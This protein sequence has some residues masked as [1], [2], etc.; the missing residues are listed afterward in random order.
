MLRT[1]SR[2]LRA[3]L[4]VALACGLPAAWASS[5]PACTLDWHATVSPAADASPANAAPG[6]AASTAPAHAGVSA[7]ASPATAA[8][9]IEVRLSFDAGPRTSTRLSLPAGWDLLEQADDGGPRLQPVAADPRQR[10][11]RHA[12][13]ERIT[14]RWRT[15]AGLANGGEAASGQGARLNPRWF[16]WI[17]DA[18]LPWPDTTAAP[19]AALTAA[20]ASTTTTTQGLARRPF[21]ACI[22][23]DAPGSARL[24]ASHG[25]AE[26]PSAR[27]VLPEASATQVQHALYAGGALA[28]R[29]ADAAGQTLTAV[30]PEPMPGEAA[31]GFGVDALA[32]R[33]ARL[34][35]AL[36]RD[37]QDDDRTPLLLMALPGMVSGGLPLQRA[38]VLQARPDLA[39][40]GAD[41]DALLAGLMLRRWTPERFGPLAHA[42]RGDAP[43]RAWFTEGFADYLAHRLLLREG[44]WTADDY[45]Q[46]LNRKIGR[47][48]AEPERGADNLRLATGAA[49]PRALADLPAARGEWLALHW[50]AALRQAG[51]PGLEATLRKLMLPAAQSRREGPLS[52]PL[53]THRLIAALRRDLGDQPL[54]ELARHIDDGVPFGFSDSSLGPCFRSG[55]RG[56]SASY[57][58]ATTADGLGACQAWQQG[59]A[60]ERRLAAAAPNDTDPAAS[61]ETAALA[62]AGPGSRTG[63]NGKAAKSGKLAKGAKAAKS[64]PGAKAGPAARSGKAGKAG[65][66]AKA[67]ATTRPAAGKPAKASQPAKGQ[68]KPRARS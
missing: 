43:L 38:L 35:G 9:Q 45:A 51:R 26:G 61:A 39:L 1:P 19:A 24:V 8:R 67:G 34:L 5:D 17:G 6:A 58:P 41:S 56:D 25:R 14:L 16:A 7:P 21:S 32:E 55:A 30:L 36:R 33:S 15:P 50:N 40:P 63:R 2:L 53:A 29:Q 20:T 4:A 49:G 48:Q 54:R 57:R 60:G 31:L 65:Q 44:L 23:L 66:G 11:L 10:E 62:Q 68:A 12:A 13:G 27:W 28:W 59:T 52:A 46:A 64:K 3:L 18:V 37:W 22:T 47:Y 42:G